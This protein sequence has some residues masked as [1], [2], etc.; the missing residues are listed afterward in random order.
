MKRCN[1]CKVKKEFSEFRRTENKCKSCVYLLNQEFE[2]TKKGMVKR[3]L[4]S[5]KCSSKTRGHPMPTYTLEELRTW[6]RCNP[7]ANALY[8]AW[9]LSGYRKGLKPSIDRLDDS[10]GYSMDNIQL[11]TW[12]ENLDKSYSDRKSGKNNKV[13]KAVIQMDLDGVFIAE[14]HSLAEAER[15]TGTHRQGIRNCFNGKQRKAGG[16]RWKTK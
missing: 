15:V 3:I 16:F 2:R 11:M 13:N 8:D 14:Y 7:L 1:E 5:Q 9:R 4:Y 6:F 12:R 10:K